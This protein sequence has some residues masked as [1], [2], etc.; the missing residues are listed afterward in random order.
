MIRRRDRTG[1]LSA[2]R[3]GK[4]PE[5]AGLGKTKWFKSRPNDGD[6]ADS[7]VPKA[8][9]VCSAKERGLGAVQRGPEGRV[10]DWKEELTGAADTCWRN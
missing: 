1:C 10:V 2:E 5:V 9:G 6:H 7:N 8:K 4:A 3:R